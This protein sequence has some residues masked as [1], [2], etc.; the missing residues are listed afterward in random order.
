MSAGGGGRRRGGG[1]GGRGGGGRRWRGGGGA[2]GGGAAA[3]RGLASA[4]S[5]SDPGG[6]RIVPDLRRM[7][8]S[9]SGWCEP[10]ELPAAGA[11]PAGAEP[12]GVGR[13]VGSGA[14]GSCG[15]LGIPGAPRRRA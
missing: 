3:A 14:A 2:G 9:G 11:L 10:V 8:E 5:T 6:G 15:E 4:R 1:G 12:S 7:S 13:P